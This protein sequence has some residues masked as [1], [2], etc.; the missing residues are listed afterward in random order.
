MT[1]QIVKK[2]NLTETAEFLEEQAKASGSSVSM[3]DGNREL[4]E[5]RL[6]QFDLV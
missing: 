5:E 6:G 2:V 3:G 1:R 4:G